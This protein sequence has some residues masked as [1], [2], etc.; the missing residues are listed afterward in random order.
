LKNISRAKYKN[1]VARTGIE[2]T[3]LLT[4]ANRLV[5]RKGRT[6]EQQW[7][8]WHCT[9]CAFFWLSARV[10][11]FNKINV[12]GFNRDRRN[13]TFNTPNFCHGLSQT[14][15]QTHLN[16]LLLSTPALLSGIFNYTAVLL[17]NQIII[18]IIFNYSSVQ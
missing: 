2:T 5:N 9:H 12:L 8:S 10:Y 7:L 1:S 3:L 6:Q 17:N 15:I 4:L 14:I 16:Q 18:P 13:R 11:F